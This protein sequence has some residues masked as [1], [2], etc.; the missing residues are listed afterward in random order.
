MFLYYSRYKIR[1][2]LIIP[3][4]HCSYFDHENNPVYILHH[5]KYSST[6]QEQ[7]KLPLRTTTYRMLRHFCYTCIKRWLMQLFW[8]S[9][10]NHLEFKYYSSWLPEEVLLDILDF[11]HEL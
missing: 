11:V 7:K 8:Y 1:P 2:R 9:D 3:C 5:L 10:S 6:E 4:L